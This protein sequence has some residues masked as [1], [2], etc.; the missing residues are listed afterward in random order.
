[1]SAEADRRTQQNRNTGYTLNC[2]GT[3]LSLK[4]PV[5]MGILNVTPDSFFDGGKFTEESLILEKAGHLLKQGAQIIDIGGMSSRPGADIISSSE[6]MS[7]LIPAVELVHRHFPKAI[8]SVDTWRAEVAEAAILQGASIIND[9]SGGELDPDII[10]VA[11]ERNAPYIL[12][13]MKGNPKTMQ[14]NPEYTDVVRDVFQSIQTRLSEYHK[15]GLKDIVIDPGFGFGKSVDDNFRLLA[16]LQFFRQMDCPIMVGLSRKSMINKTLNIRSEDALNGTTTLNTL[17]LK[18]GANILRVHDVKEAVECIA[19]FRRF[20]TCG[21]P[22][23][24]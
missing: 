10:R 23:R 9:I 1:M 20:Q 21:Q 8:I 17:A 3:L 7:R 11:V 22:G 14:I 18:E 2:R 15:M 5:V 4:E 6:E 24:D 16:N 19:L 12:M 13:H